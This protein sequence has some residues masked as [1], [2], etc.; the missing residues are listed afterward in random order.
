VEWTNKAESFKGIPGKIYRQLDSPAAGATAL[1][2]AKKELDPHSV[3]N[4]GVLI[5]PRDC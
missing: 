2:A 1:R 4:P 5:D 3:F